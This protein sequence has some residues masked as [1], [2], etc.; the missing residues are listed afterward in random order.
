MSAPGGRGRRL[1]RVGLFVVVC[2]LLV[3]TLPAVATAGVTPE[4]EIEEDIEV[5]SNV[6][7]LQEMEEDLSADYFLQDDI[8]ASETAEWNGGAGFDPI[9]DESNPFTGTF[10]GQ[11][12]VIENLTIDRSDEQYVGLFG[13]ADGSDVVLQNVRLEGLDIHGEE[14]VGG[15]AGKIRDGAVL[16][17]S[18]EGQVIAENQLV[19]GMVGRP[20]S[21]TLDQRLSARTTVEGG[22]VGHL[23][24]IGGLVGRSTGSTT[25]SVAYAQSEVT[26]ENAGGLVGSSSTI[27]SNFDQMYSASVVNGEDAGAMVGVIESSG[28]VFE[29]SVYWDTTLESDE[30]G[31]DQSDGSATNEMVELETDQMTG[32]DATEFMDGLDFEQVWEPVTEPADDYPVFFWEET[33]PGA[34]EAVMSVSSNVVT[35]DEEALFNAGDSTGNITSYEW[36]FGD[37]TTA[38]GVEVSHSYN[39]SGEYVVE[40][41][42]SGPTGLGT[43]TEEIVVLAEE[44]LGFSTSPPSPETA[45]RVTFESVAA[46][47]PSWEFGDGETASGETVV[48]AYTEPGTYEVTLTDE[49]TGEELTRELTTGEPELAITSLMPSYTGPVI[50]FD[51]FNITAEYPISVDSEFPVESVTLEVNDEVVEADQEEPGAWSATLDLVEKG[52]GAGTDILTVN[53]TATDE[54]GAT[55]S[56]ELHYPYVGVPDWLES[57]ADLADTFGAGVSSLPGEGEAAAGI[58]AKPIDIDYQTNAPGIPD[59]IRPWDNDINVEKE[60][61]IDLLLLLPDGDIQ[62][63]GSPA[64]NISKKGV[65]FGIEGDTEGTI[66]VDY[67][68]GAFDLV[69]VDTSIEGSF[70]RDIPFDVTAQSLVDTVPGVPSWI[71]SRVPDTGVSFEPRIKVG[72]NGELELIEEDND[73]TINHSMVGLFGGVEGSAGNEFGRI[74]EVDGSLYGTVGGEFVPAFTTPIPIAD[75]DIPL[76]VGVSGELET[77][78]IPFINGFSGELDYSFGGSITD[79]LPAQEQTEAV[80][81][82][83]DGDDGSGWE[84]APKYGTQPLPTV[85]AVG[86]DG[87]AE[88]PW[89]LE[90]TPTTETND[91][92]TDSPTEDRRP[93]LTAHDGQQLVVW[94]DQD[95]EKEVADGRDLSLRHHDGE[96]WGESK[97]IT[98]DEFHDSRPDV[99]TLDDGTTLAVWERL[100]EQMA[101]GDAPGEALSNMTVTAASSDID[102]P[103]EWSGLHELAAEPDSEA[104]V[105]SPAIGAAEDR[106]LVAWE[107]DSL[108]SDGFADVTVEYAIVE[109]DGDGISVVA[110]GG[111]LEGFAP[112]VAARDDGQFDLVYYDPA[113]GTRDGTVVRQTVDDGG[114]LAGTVEHEVEQFHGLSAGPDSVVW[115]EGSPGPN[116]ILYDAGGSVE[117]VDHGA[118]FSRVQDIQLVHDDDRTVIAYSGSPDR[119]IDRELVYQTREEEGWSSARSVAGETGDLI[120]TQPDAALLDGERDFGFVYNGKPAN[121]SDGVNDIF[122]ASG[123]FG[124]AYELAAVDGPSNASVGDEVDVSAAVR[125][126]GQT[127]DQSVTVTLTAGDTVLDS[128]EFPDGLD[129][130]ENVSATLSGV[131]DADGVLNVTVQETAG[132]QDQHVEPW[133]QRT[134]QLVFATLELGVADISVASTD[135]EALNVTVMNRGEAQATDVPVR[136]TDDGTTL[137]NVT[138][139]TVPATETVTTTVDVDPTELNLSSQTTAAI[140]PDGT[141]PADHLAEFVDRR[142][143]FV[144]QPDLTVHDVTYEVD[145]DETVTEVILSNDGTVDVPTTVVVETANGTTLGSETVEMGAD[146][147]DTVFRTVTVPFDDIVPSDT[148]LVISANPTILDV[149]ATSLTV[150]DEFGPVLSGPPPLPG[151]VGPPQD[152][153]GD[154][155]YEDVDG[156]GTFDIFDVQT[157]FANLD[158]AAAY[159]S[160]FDFTGGGEVG[161]TD[162]QAL[163]EKL[164]D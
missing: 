144:A 46:T 132:S 91:R 136:V 85:S 73:V 139:P 126:A 79:I 104:F 56:T 8:D 116:T 127:S 76:E 59:A 28:D 18:V 111:P 148:P 13:E 158:T 54:L 19:G 44:E 113:N 106:W 11:G 65:G 1:V 135:A 123:A 114:D 77:A 42:V 108:A 75:I 161:I 6:T 149:D 143:S 130:G 118:D 17:S 109:P 3:A 38:E 27:N 4:A 9:G 51:A 62:V 29:D 94:S 92:L 10:D 98:D 35:V 25:I 128:V 124:P 90:P 61:G 145:G 45:E 151:A 69:A 16:N 164:T 115:T 119:S 39:E 32:E 131:V 96:E 150:T 63:T 64:G 47:E 30:Y 141:M 125:N 7:D 134:E 20:W 102:T 78:S 55:D 5:I 82:G 36:D 112:S 122:A 156:D 15:L 103:S 101:E 74:F 41:T 67:E 155:L 24:G 37:G 159:P 33:V 97:S 142:T 70:F 57:L 48:H 93:A 81:D 12:H 152:L 100:A 110:E 117:A 86:S 84:L 66:E 88:T 43:A 129:A 60:I 153:T 71:E 163:F 83:G 80:S 49:A 23:R 21:A 87:G 34:P 26:G 31:V 89:P 40:L 107:R 121:V 53:V 146:D 147:D 99:A 162:V 95:E 154:G 120:I 138:L 133:V 22:D 140:D 68:D 50:G 160:A 2:G 58:S 72:A 157:L 14:R 137:A 105:H 52:E